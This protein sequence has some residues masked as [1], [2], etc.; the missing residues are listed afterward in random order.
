MVSNPHHI[1][2]MGNQLVVVHNDGSQS[3]AFQTG[4]V[5]WLLNKNGLKHIRQYGDQLVV[6]KSDN[7]TLTAYPTSTNVWMTKYVEDYVPPVELFQWPLPYPNN[8]DDYGW[9][10]DPVGFHHGMDWSYPAGTE[11]AC[12]GT[13][14][15]IQAGWN[16]ALGHYTIVQH[17][18]MQGFWRR[19]AYA[20]QSA[21]YVS[22]GDTVS[23]GQIIGAVGNTGSASYGNHLHYETW[24]N[25]PDL[26]DPDSGDNRVDPILWMGKY[27]YG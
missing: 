9:R 23:K 1:K 3:T 12:A 7:S 8:S 4:G 18:V 27:Q 15:V 11:F 21:M 26:Q 20:H 25:D 5:L 19:T 2:L 10:T 24:T 22:A 14:T 6:T 17:A 13:G 16:S